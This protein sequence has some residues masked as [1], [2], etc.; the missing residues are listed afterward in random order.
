MSR[1]SPSNLTISQW[2][3]KNLLEAHPPNHD[4]H[5]MA[6]GPHTPDI[7]FFEIDIR[8]LTL[9]GIAIISDRVA[10]Y[11]RSTYL[12]FSHIYVTYPGT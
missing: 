10:T 6:V 7:Y 4:T 8:N 12:D 2:A 3:K 9:I 5:I 11:H 1:K